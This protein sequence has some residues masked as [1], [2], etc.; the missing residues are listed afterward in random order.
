MPAGA[1][2]ATP[3]NDDNDA[4]EDGHAPQQQP[5]ALTRLC[6]IPDATINDVASRLL[7]ASLALNLQTD[8]RSHVPCESL[9]HEAVANGSQRPRLRHLRQHLSIAGHMQACGGLTSDHVIVEV[10]AGKAG[11]SRSLCR[12]HASNTYAP[13]AFLR[14]IFVTFFAGTCWLTGKASRVRRTAG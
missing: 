11:L 8:V 7:S 14:C 9:M 4:N 10:G 3:S 2:A 13:R 1:A 12:G 5:S 6:D